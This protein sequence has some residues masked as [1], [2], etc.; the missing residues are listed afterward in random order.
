MVLQGALDGVGRCQGASHGKV[1]GMKGVRLKWM[2]GGTQWSMKVLV[3]GCVDAQG[4]GLMPWVAGE[5]VSWLDGGG[6]D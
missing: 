3:G 5:T 2:D 6:T 4:C 1:Q